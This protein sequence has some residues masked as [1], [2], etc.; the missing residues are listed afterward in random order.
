MTANIRE[1]HGQGR[2]YLDQDSPMI[3]LRFAKGWEE[4]LSTLN[5]GSSI[6][7]RGKMK[8]ADNT[9]IDFEQCELV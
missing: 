7:F 1:N 4:Q 2:V 5:R 8:A 9:W 3:V 6:T